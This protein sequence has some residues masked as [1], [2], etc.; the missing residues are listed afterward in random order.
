MEKIMN[1]ESA[2]E[3]IPLNNESLMK[4]SVG[5]IARVKQRHQKHH[6]KKLKI[7]PLEI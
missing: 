6:G 5:K 7:D 3:Q 1:A 2:L 4:I